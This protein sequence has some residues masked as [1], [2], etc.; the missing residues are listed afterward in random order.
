MPYNACNDFAVDF[1]FFLANCEQLRTV[2][3]L[4]YSI[5]F[6]KVVAKA[7]RSLF[8]CPLLLHQFVLERF[9]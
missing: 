1:M 9:H 4:Q 8:K 5:T 3:V 7:G 2:I 6:E